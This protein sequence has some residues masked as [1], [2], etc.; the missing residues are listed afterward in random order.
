MTLSNTGEMDGAEVV[1]LYVGK[2]AAAVFRPNKELKG[3][4]KVFLRKGESRTVEIPFDDKTFRF[5]NGKTGRWEIEGGEY[6]IMVGACVADI[7][8]S[9]KI[10]VEGTMEE[11]PYHWET[12]PSYYSGLIRQVEDKEY[13][14]LLG[15]PI[16]SGKWQ[17]DLDTN[18]AI[19]QMYYAK[20]WLARLIYQKLT[21]MKKA[22]EEK[23]KPDLNI[24]FIYNMP[25]RGIAKM[26]GGAVSMEMVDGIVD[27]VNGHFFRGLKKTVCGYFRNRR[28]NR[29]YERM[30]GRRE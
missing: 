4:Q 27:M 29:A 15:Y 17:G 2:P 11:P 14:A 10:T 22:S 26:T 13:E 19:C 6:L 21:A 8:L 30:L 28:L 5:W 12:L 25:F 1:Q 16:P 3:F 24:L 18:D 9:G 7:R 20:S 23:G